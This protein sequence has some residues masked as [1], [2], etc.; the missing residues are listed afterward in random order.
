MQ[1]ALDTVTENQI[2]QALAG[3]S[4]NRTVLVIAHRLGTIKAAE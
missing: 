2:Q 1:S 4:R 3:L